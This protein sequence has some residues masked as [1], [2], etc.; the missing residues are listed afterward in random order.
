MSVGGPL[1]TRRTSSGLS[2]SAYPPP[3]GEPSQPA[4]QPQS[5]LKPKRKRAT[6]GQLR[7]LNSVFQSTF[8]PSTE[9]RI[10]LGKELNMSPR[11]VQIWF[12]NKRQSWRATKT[13]TEHATT[14]QMAPKPTTPSSSQSF[15]GSG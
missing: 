1:R 7:V 9:L 15:P 13:K 2:Q 12:Q 14:Q 5:N 11:T 6:S 4:S 10:A 8:F 3:S